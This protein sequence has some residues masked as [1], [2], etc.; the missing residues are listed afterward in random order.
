MKKAKPELVDVYSMIVNIRALAEA[1]SYL[2]D[3]KEA[4]SARHAINEKL[5]EMLWKVPA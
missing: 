5:V 2:K 3:V 1:C 4:E